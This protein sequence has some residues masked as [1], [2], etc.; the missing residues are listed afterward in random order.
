M[1][2]RSPHPTPFVHPF[3]ER[4]PAFSK[5][6]I[7][8]DDAQELQ[9]RFLRAQDDVFV[10][11]CLVDPEGRTLTLTVQTPWP[12]RGAWARFFAAVAGLDAK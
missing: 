4:A 1:P 8:C 5:V 9:E 10:E 11:D 2:R 7:Q 3:D 6:Q 12:R